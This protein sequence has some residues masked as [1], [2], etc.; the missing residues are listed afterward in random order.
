MFGDYST[1]PSS[2]PV[3]FVIEGISSQDM[4]DIPMENLPINRTCVDYIVYVLHH[5]F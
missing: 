2:R 1:T 4:L 5:F 3:T